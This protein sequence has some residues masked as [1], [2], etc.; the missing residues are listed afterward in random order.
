MHKI[1]IVGRLGN[2]PELRHTKGGDAVVN[3]SMADTERW[4]DKQSGETNSRTEWFR[5][6]CFGRQAEIIAQYVKKG[7]NLAITGKL[8]T[9]EWEKEGVKQ[10]TTE[11][12]VDGFELISVRL[13]GNQSSSQPQS[14]GFDS[15][16]GGSFDDSSDIPF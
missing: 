9:S 10:Y 11:I 6:K 12:I 5:C 15:S 13:D 7:E 1:H 4:K 2:D 14:S 8:R 3:F 16:G